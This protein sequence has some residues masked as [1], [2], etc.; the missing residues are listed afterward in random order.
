MDSKGPSLYTEAG[1]SGDLSRSN[2]EDSLVDA[3]LISADALHSAIRNEFQ[4]ITTNRHST[5]LSALHV[6]FV[7]LSM[8]VAVLCEL[9]VG[10]EDVCNS[11]LG[12]VKGQSA[13]LFGKACLWVLVLL[14]TKHA[15]HHL[16]QAR[17]VGYLNF[18]RQMEGAEQPPLCVQ[19]AG[20]VL[21][22][23]V[24]AAPLSAPLTTYL[25]LA[26]LSVELLVALPWL[27]F[28][29][30]KVTQFNRKR[31][32]PDAE[33][34]SHHVSVTSLPTETGFRDG[35]SLEEVVEKQ[36]DLIEY[37]KQRNTLL[38]KR[39]LNLSTAQH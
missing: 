10:Q 17:T 33:E 7:V 3:P 21:L 22:L 30:V 8:C 12:Q 34:C 20:N 24:L 4:P 36:A 9:K 26:I 29:T 28:Y 23:V 37:L 38:S 2:D 18:Y 25:L 14:Y 19:S 32:A 6:V 15:Q 39:L 31:P 13:I 16:R 11:V 5:L 1:P 35:S 27:L